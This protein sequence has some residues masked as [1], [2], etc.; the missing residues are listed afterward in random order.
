MKFNFR[1]LVALAV[2]VIVAYVAF[3]AVRLQSY[4]GSALTFTVPT[5]SVELVN[6]SDEPAQIRAYARSLFHVARND[7]EEA[8]VATR[9]GSGRNAL[10]VFEGELPPGSSELQITRGSDV[11]FELSSTGLLNATVTPRKSG[12]T[13]TILVV[14]ALVILGSLYYASHVT[15]HAWLRLIRRNATADK[16]GEQAASAP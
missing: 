9:Q 5:G 1:A 12:E 2:I 6:D 8:L 7:S 15:G 13:T 10:Y 4:S 14:A 11:T 16:V 3:D